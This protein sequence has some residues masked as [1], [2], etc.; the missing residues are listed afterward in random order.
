M[1]V[2]DEE[3]P[4][5]ADAANA[6][7]RE[8]KEAGVYVFSGGLDEDVEPVRLMPYLPCNRR[9]Y[10]RSVIRPAVGRRN[11]PGVFSGHRWTHGGGRVT[12]SVRLWRGP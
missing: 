7:I 5:V 12:A 6:V 2:P 9:L 8:A 1:D 3:G 4:D 11:T 10:D